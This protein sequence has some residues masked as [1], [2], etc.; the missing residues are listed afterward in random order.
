MFTYSLLGLELFAYKAKFNSEGNIDFVDGEYP[1][2]NFN[3]FYN[4]FTTVFIVLTNDEWTVIYYD[5]YRTAGS[6]SATIFFLTL[7]IIGQ[8]ILLNLFLAIL[9]EN[10]DEGAVK[11]QHKKD[12]KTFGAS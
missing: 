11:E 10:F 6:A 4:A 1:D 9:L 12:F 7:I 5:M 2:S 3:K 8:K